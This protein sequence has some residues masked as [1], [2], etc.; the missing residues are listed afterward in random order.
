METSSAEG[1]SLGLEGVL[2]EAIV[3]QLKPLVI[4]I[5]ERIKCTRLQNY[6]YCLLTHI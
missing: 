5:E 2:T 3:N 4:S 6:F 1:N